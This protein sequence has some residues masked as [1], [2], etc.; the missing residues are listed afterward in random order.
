MWIGRGLNRCI[1]ID[2]YIC[3][4]IQP[5]GGDRERGE[6]KAK[7]VWFGFIWLFVICY[8]LWW[9]LV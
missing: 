3:V 9:V 6:K 1:Y 5:R 8:L 7:G 2:E 4:Y